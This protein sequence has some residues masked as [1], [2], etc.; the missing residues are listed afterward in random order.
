MKIIIGKTAGFCYGVERAVKGA[1]EELNNEDKK[2][3]CLGEIV[4]NREVIKDLENRGIEVIE[5]ISQVKEKN[6]KTIIRAHGIPKEIY[7]KCEENK[8]EYVDYTCPKV[9]N[10]H[11]IAEEYSKKGYYIILVGASKHPENIGTISYCGKYYSIIEQVEDCQK[12][13]EDVKNSKKDKC[14][15]IAQTTYHLGKFAQ[16]EKILKENLSEGID[17]KIKN[18]ICQATQIRQE[19]TEDIAKKVQYM[20]I[21]G[22]KN[23]SN[24]K[25]LYE[26]ASKNCKNTICIETKNEINLE[27][28]KNIESVGIMAGASTPQE[29]ITEV[30]ELISSII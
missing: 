20:I 17:L 15:V 12:A 28:L 26:I 19:E 24:T 22:G 21:I 3:Y 25:K 29:S 6:S 10:I 11:K 16:I 7:D 5:D 2:I 27:D 14:L 13:I 1:K 23:S 8:I 30:H 4:H 9:L 18:T